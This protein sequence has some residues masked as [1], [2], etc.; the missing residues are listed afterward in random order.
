MTSDIGTSHRFDF[1]EEV[2]VTT[3]PPISTKI[4]GFDFM[5][6]VIVTTKPPIS[7]KIRGLD[8]VTLGCQEELHH[9]NPPVKNDQICPNCTT[10]G[11]NTSKNQPSRCISKAIWSF[12]SVITL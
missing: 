9:Q 8:L 4:R 12:L 11:N 5:E 1:M 7:T 3:K 10:L 2:I 6:E